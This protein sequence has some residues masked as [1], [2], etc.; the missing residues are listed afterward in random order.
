MKKFVWTVEVFDG[1]SW[2]HW[3]FSESRSEAR[4]IAATCRPHW[5]G[6]RVVKFVRAS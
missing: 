5:D 4:M 2:M 1:Y 3:S 6:I